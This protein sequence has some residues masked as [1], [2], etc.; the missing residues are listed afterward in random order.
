VSVLL[1]DDVE[2][3]CRDDHMACGELAHRAAAKGEGR[4]EGRG[5][6]YG[7]KGL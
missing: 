5:K 7:G 3:T 4:R 6:W 1:E 2:V